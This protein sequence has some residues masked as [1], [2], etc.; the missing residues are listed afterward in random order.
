MKSVATSL[1]TISGHLEG[2]QIICSSRDEGV[3]RRASVEVKLTS[4][5]Y[6]TSA[7]NLLLSFAQFE[8]EDTEE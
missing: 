8:R 7:L 4:W 1:L 6:S 2:I 3:R 5:C